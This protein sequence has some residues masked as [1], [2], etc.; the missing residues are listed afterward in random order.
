M[1]EASETRTHPVFGELVWQSEYSYWLAKF[2]ERLEVI[3]DPGDLDRDAFLEPAA[4][5]FERVRKAE[6]RILRKAINEDLLELYNGTW[7]RNANPELSA[8]ELAA[9]LVLGLIEIGQGIP[10]ILHYEAGHL[11]GNHI[12][13]LELDEQLQFGAADFRG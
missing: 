3:V 10:V 1:A 13:A 8:T 11:F 5:L 9:Q 4:K 7:R 6:P 12:I 2:G